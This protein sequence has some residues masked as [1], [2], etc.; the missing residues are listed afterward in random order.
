MDNFD[1]KK[2]LAEGRLQKEKVEE[3]SEGYAD[4][5]IEFNGRDVDLNSA[6]FEYDKDGNDRTSVALLSV[7]YSDGEEL[8]D[9]ELEAFEEMYYDDLPYWVYDHG[10]ATPRGY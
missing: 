6:E 2:Y 3:N 1:L 5:M 9:Q 4:N 8:N 10:N 7:S